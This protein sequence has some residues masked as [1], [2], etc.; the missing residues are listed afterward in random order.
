MTPPKFQGAQLILP[1]QVLSPQPSLSPSRCAES[2]ASRQ[3]PPALSASPGRPPFPLSGNKQF[4][5]HTRRLPCSRLRRQ[6]NSPEP[7]PDGRPSPPLRL[8]DSSLGPSAGVGAA[9]RPPLQGRPKDAKAAAAGTPGAAA[10]NLLVP[11]EKAE[12]ERERRRVQFSLASLEPAERAGLP[13]SLT[14]ARR[15]Q[16]VGARALARAKDPL[17]LPSSFSPLPPSLSLSRPVNG[18]SRRAS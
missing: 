4:H 9:V 14:R 7:V 18:I 2:A 13:G 11:R 10:K 12:G 17:P 8:L 6:P 1:P 15:R 16:P 5:A 3:P